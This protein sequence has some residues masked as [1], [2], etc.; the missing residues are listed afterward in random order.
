[1][2]IK[3]SVLCTAYNQEDYIE[4]TLKGFVNQK[5][6]F[7]FEVLIN[8]DC[9]TDNT[10][11]IIKKYQQLYPNIIK[12]IYQVENQYSKNVFITKD[13]LLP[14]AKGK[15][16]AL[17]EGDDY[18]IDCLK[19]Q[20]QCDYMDSHENCSLCIHNSIQ[21]DSMSNFVCN[22]IITDTDSNIDCEKV[23]LGGGRFCMT[24]SIMAPRDL[25]LS[26]PDYGTRY[27]DYV[28]QAYFASRG[29]TYCFSEYMSA[30]RLNAKGSWSEEMNKNNSMK[31]V[32]FIDEQISFYNSFNIDSEFRFDSIIKKLKS[33]LY[34]KRALILKNPSSIDGFDIDFKRVDKRLKIKYLILKIS[35]ALYNLLAKKRKWI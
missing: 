2:G 11:N 31:H 17:C 34:I 28:W 18:W 35:P 22:H 29:E 24:N 6:D 25:A 5:T 33:N 20:K 23:L 27:Y 1:M 19:L 7:K 15:Y 30:Y 12:P 9:S 8:D 16:I 4:E 10:K 3:V 14:L 26:I 32:K 13:I 21:V